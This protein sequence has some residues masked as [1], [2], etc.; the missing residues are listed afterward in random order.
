M[1]HQEEPPFSLVSASQEGKTNLVL[2]T[3][4]L[5]PQK[6]GVCSPKLWHGLKV[7]V[8][9]K[10]GDER[11]LRYAA[12]VNITILLPPHDFLKG[13]ER[14]VAVERKEKWIISGYCSWLADL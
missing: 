1:V 11:D 5:D 2:G 13:R 7:C 12:T 4:S 3:H 9:L 8:L 6:K 14:S 10:H